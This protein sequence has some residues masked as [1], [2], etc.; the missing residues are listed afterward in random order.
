[1]FTSYRL[2]VVASV[3]VT[4]LITANIV[5]V[6]QT[7]LFGI[8][9]PAGVVVFPL[10]YIFGDILTEVYGYRVARRVIW[11]G[12]VCNLI[13][14]LFAWVAQSLP[15]LPP[16][17]GLEEQRAYERILGQTPQILVASFLAYLAG[18]FANSFVLA[19]LKIVTGG[20]WLWS[21][22]ISSTL[23]GQGLDSG[24]FLSLLAVFGVLPAYLLVGIVLAHWLSKTAF[25]VVATPFT[26]LVVNYLKRKEQLDTFDYD[27]NFNPLLVR[28]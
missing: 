2:V 27:T 5:V 15:L 22:T 23:V 13:F 20:R 10:S 21:R 17:W 8:P 26:Y 9:L 24:V 14:V 4:C 1:M 28:D 3:F 16:A 12:F 11:L 18:E 25:E 6:K 7:S 19:K